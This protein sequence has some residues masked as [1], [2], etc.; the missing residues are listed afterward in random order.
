MRDLENKRGRDLD[1]MTFSWGDQKGLSSSQLVM[2]LPILSY[3]IES[4]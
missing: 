4:F 1:I 2:G 3:V